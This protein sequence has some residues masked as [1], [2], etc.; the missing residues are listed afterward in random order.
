[1]KIKIRYVEDSSA[2]GLDFCTANTPS[3]INAVVALV[4]DKGIYNTERAVEMPY[5]SHQLCFN[6]AEAWCEVVG[7]DPK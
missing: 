5:H 2:E 3:E 6:D 1:M 7:S 4:K